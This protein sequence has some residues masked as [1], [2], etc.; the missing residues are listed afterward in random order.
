MADVTYVEIND[1][2]KGADRISVPSMAYMNSV[3]QLRRSQTWGFDGTAIVADKAY[4]SR[5]RLEQ[6]WQPRFETGAAELARSLEYDDLNRVVNTVTYDQVNPTTGNA[7][8]T[9]YNGFTQV[10]TNPK[11]QRRT[12]RRDVLSR[13]QRTT[14]DANKNTDFSYDVFGNLTK[15]IDPNTNEITN[16]WGQTPFKMVE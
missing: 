5:G 11:S 12:D 13:V 1:N 2:F 3:G 15:T 4:D 8:R 9:D 7:T 10:H 16:K 6:E 14:D